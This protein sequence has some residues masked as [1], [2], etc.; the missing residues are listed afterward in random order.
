MIVRTLPLLLKIHS[1]GQAQLHKRRV[2]RHAPKS[3][4]GR[5]KFGKPVFRGSD[6]YKNV[7]LGKRTIKDGE[8]AAVWKWN[9]EHTEHVGPKLVFLFHSQVRFLDRFVASQH[10][11]LRV[12]RRDGLIEHL[13]GPTTMFLNP[14]KHE[15]IAVQDAAVL[16]ATEVLL[17]YSEGSKGEASKVM[18]GPAV[19]VP[20][21]SERII[22]F[23]WLVEETP[24]APLVKATRSKLSLIPQSIPVSVKATTSDEAHVTVNLVLRFQPVCIQTM[25][26]STLDPLTDLRNAISADAVC[27]V[28]RYEYVTLHEGAKTL[29]DKDEY[30]ELNKLA[31]SI[32][33]KILGVSFVSSEGS[34]ELGSLLSAAIESRAS[35]QMKKEKSE[36]EHEIQDMALNAELSRLTREQERRKLVHTQE[37][38]QAK[39]KHTSALEMAEQA[40]EQ[41]A[42]HLRVEHEGEIQFYEQLRTRAGVDVTAVLVAREGGL[43]VSRKEGDQL[44]QDNKTKK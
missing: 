24:S 28:K 32:G 4:M 42:R 6:Y 36:K 8:C 27:V 33:F 16:E 29:T 3:I 18:K 39:E 13:P 43:S 15:A 40:F 25:I 41:K 26:G 44:K 34:K 9:G 20:A 17:L 37:L 30:K 22:S 11:Y 31:S 2:S 35:L 19:V 5:F 23:T 12:Q 10:Q 1:C 7:T 14:T 21:T 38:E